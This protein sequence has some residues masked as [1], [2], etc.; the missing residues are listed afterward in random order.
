[1]PGGPQRIAVLFAL[2]LAACG[3]G[4][5]RPELRH[6][7]LDSF[8]SDTSPSGR[9]VVLIGID[10]ASWDYLTPLFEAGEL[11][12][13]ARVVREG[14][15]GRLRSI[16]CHFT[17]P[18]WT[19]MLT[20]VLPE[21]HG[22]YSFGS[23]S[24]AE[25]RFA[26]V[27]SNEVEAATVWDVA[28]RAG[29]EVAVVGVPAT[30]PPHPV[31]GSMVTG[32]MTP[33]TR[34]P[35]LQLARAPARRRPPD[36][37]LTSH[38]PV[39]TAA[40]EDAHNVLLP[41]FLDTRDDGETAYDEAQLV[42]LRK[43]LGTTQRR[44]LSEQRFPVGR[45]SPWVRVRLSDERPPRDGFL[46]IR[47]DSPSAEGLSYLLTPTFL[48]IRHPFTH[49]PALARELSRRF[50]YY[51]PHEFLSGDILESVTAEAAGHARFF[52]DETEWDLYLY[53]FG[54]SDN[55]HH[56]IG[57][58]EPALPIYRTIDAFVGQVLASV[59]PETTVVIAS[60]HGFGEFDHSVD[61]NQHLASLGLL[62][63]KGAGV[64]D[65]ARTLVFHN[66]WHLHFNRKLLT[67]EALSRHGI[68]VTGEETPED[69][70]A[71]HLQNIAR[72]LRS[73][74]GEPFPVELVRLPAE[75]VG[76]APDMAVQATSEFWLEFWNVDRPS[77]EIVRPLVG[78]ERWKHARDGIV[79][80][81]GAGI[82]AGKHLGVVDIQDVA[83]TLLDLLGL[84]VA[85]DLDGAP[86]PLLEPAAAQARILHRVASFADLRRERVEA[87]E[88]PAS[89]EETLR[90]LGYV[91]D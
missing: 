17:P 66:M 12:A 63:W 15:S 53:V 21:R 24:E 9:R 7:D 74:S 41:T 19:S 72:N 73:A 23:W 4:G 58:G 80:A 37:E 87:P 42:T 8:A 29:L 33:K 2:L 82:R 13:L 86:L 62:R 22:I 51:L 49:P 3:V 70:L 48:R 47:F 44:T 61:L 55:A 75:A 1:M 26:K 91:R 56:L 46:K 43:G 36:P 30:Y 18:A 54:Q 31:N 27:T 16:E 85:D 10:G 67:A 40:F 69:A 5:V 65:H 71:R 76:N 20:G 39:L 50:G 79:A 90:A 77:P 32:I 81:W 83:P 25:Q 38:S 35:P 14:T 59:G 60:D 11:P 84:P 88:D 57:F 78:D 64:I 28:S 45:F 6:A 89:F 68:E 34:I 52:L